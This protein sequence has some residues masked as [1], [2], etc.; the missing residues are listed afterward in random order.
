MVLI[1]ASLY[2][3]EHIIKV[4]HRA[5]FYY[6]G[7]APAPPTAA[8]HTPLHAHAMKGASPA[9]DTATAVLA[10]IREAAGGGGGGG[11]GKSGAG[12]EL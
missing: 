7:G 9:T 11:G 8:L 10:A 1:A 5:R 3:P 4:L 12:R 2:L 6:S